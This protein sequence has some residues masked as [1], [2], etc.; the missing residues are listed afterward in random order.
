M[1]VF[2]CACGKQL[3]AREEDAGKVVDC[4][5]CG[6]VAVVPCPLLAHPVYPAHD[7]AARDSAARD[8]AA[9]DSASTVRRQVACLS[10]PLVVL[11]GVTAALFLTL[12]ILLI[13]GVRTGFSRV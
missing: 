2:S 9:R 1:I 6:G 8:S 10:T 11:I 7:G 5:G 12:G 3:Q 13:W 4:P